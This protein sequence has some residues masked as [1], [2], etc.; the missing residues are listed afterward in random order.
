[1]KT[2]LGV[3]RKRFQHY[4]KVVEP[5]NGMEINNGNLPFLPDD[6]IIMSFLMRVIIYKGG[7]I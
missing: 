5:K 3:A 7:R 4:Y 6:L 2:R 1:M